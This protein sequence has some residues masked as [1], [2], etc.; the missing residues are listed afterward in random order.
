MY[1]HSFYL[2]LFANIGNCELS[3]FFSEVLHI[4]LYLVRTVSSIQFYSLII[5]LL[6]PIHA[7]PKI[8]NNAIATCTL[9]LTSQFKNIT[10]CYGLDL[11][12]CYCV[13]HTKIVLNYFPI[14]I[15]MTFKICF[16]QLLKWCICCFI[17]PHSRDL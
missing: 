16:N 7:I 17:I 14:L 5:D 13:M 15:N 10:E 6:T 4:L 12:C 9:L 11:F 2:L 3:P 1:F 8:L